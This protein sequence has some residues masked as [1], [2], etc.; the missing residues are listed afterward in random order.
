MQHQ[1]LIQKAKALGIQVKDISQMM[2]KQA[3]IL[4]YQ[5]Q[6]E[7]IVNG[8]PT[9]WINVRSQFYCDNKQL[10]KLVYEKKGI[11]YP[12]SCTFKTPDEAHLASFFTADKNYV[13]KPIDETNGVGIHLNIQNLSDIKNYYKV[14]QL[15]FSDKVYLLEEQIDGQDL[16]IH[17]IKGK[18]VAACIR[19]PAFVVGNGINTL[20]E[21]IH[22]RQ[23]VMSN[24]NPNNQLTIDKITLNLLSQQKIQLQ[25]IP[26]K[27]QKIQLKQVSNMAQGGIAI[28]VSNE[29]HPIYQEWAT[30]LTDYLGTGYMGLDFITSNHQ[31]NPKDHTC[32]LEINARADWLHH[33]FSEGQTHDMAS[34]ILNAIFF[35]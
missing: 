1:Q 2:Q 22:Q 16:R 10:T 11:P 6:S 24:Q 34:I 27:G 14:M 26:T 35:D 5:N 19:E 18:I 13:C 30:A 32:I 25:N 12:K 9:S 20:Q 3:A 17:I 4:T 7:L 15:H 23:A 29:I 33:T 21:L 31:K 28:D 8:V